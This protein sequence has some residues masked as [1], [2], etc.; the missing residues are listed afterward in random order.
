MLRHIYGLKK[1]PT[2]LEW[3]TFLLHFTSFS[4]LANVINGPTTQ[5]VIPR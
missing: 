5:T 2:T 3:D 1:Q 4:D